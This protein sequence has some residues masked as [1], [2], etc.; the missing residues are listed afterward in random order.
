MTAV[1]SKYFSPPYKSLLIADGLGL[2]LFSISGAQAAEILEVHPIIIIIMGLFTGVLGGILRDVLCQEIPVLF[3]PDV[4]LYG[5][6]AISGI[7]T[8]L[9]LQMLGINRELS[10]II[11]MLVI[12]VFRFV[13]M[14]FNLTLPK[15]SLKTR[16]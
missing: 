12:A 11:S 7:V 9:I 6:T 10:S 16:N 14:K 2:A 5:T 13:S 8:Y 1:Y 15:F 3:K 4:T